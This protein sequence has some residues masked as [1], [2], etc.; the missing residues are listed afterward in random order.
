[1][2][3]AA[4]R[5][6]EWRCGDVLAVWN[7]VIGCAGDSRV[8]NMA[9]ADEPSQTWS[10]PG[11]F[12]VQGCENWQLCD[13]WLKISSMVPNVTSRE[14]PGP[15]LSRA[16]C[17]SNIHTQ[18]CPARLHHMM[19]FPLRALWFSPYSAGELRSRARERRRCSRYPPA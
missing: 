4:W 5:G 19:P 16:H 17:P 10:D 9:A 3:F 14:R 11:N 1:M 7:A 13:R 6:V 12:R 18:P 8:V 15:K 2:C